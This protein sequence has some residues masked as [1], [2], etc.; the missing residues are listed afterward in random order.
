MPYYKNSFSVFRFSGNNY[1][2]LIFYR[3]AFPNYD[4]YLKKQMFC[5]YINNEKCNKTISSRF[6][7]LKC[8][9]NQWEY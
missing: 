2:F 3:Y 6:S 9:Q 5:Y 8:G 1:Y 4:F 7:F